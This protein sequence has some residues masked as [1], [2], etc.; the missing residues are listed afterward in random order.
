[1]SP[2]CGDGGGGCLPFLYFLRRVRFFIFCNARGEW[3]LAGIKT[4]EWPL[5]SGAMNGA[6]ACSGD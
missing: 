1:M 5:R 2:W 4:T 6:S 3:G